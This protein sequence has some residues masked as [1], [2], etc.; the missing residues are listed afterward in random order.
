MA[1]V[2]GEMLVDS[3]DQNDTPV[4]V[5][6]RNE[7]FAKRVNFRVAHDLVFNSGGKLLV[8]QLARTRTRHP[9][10]WGSSVAAYLFSG[11][12]YEAAARR[13][14]A[15][16]LGIEGVPLSEVGKASMEDS[17]CQKFIGIFATIHDGPF[18]FD[19]EHIDAIEFL[20]LGEIGELHA[21]GSRRFTPTF[22][23]VLD[24]YESRM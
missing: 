8:Q 14:L 13:R 6:R 4:G 19:P 3:V 17:G 18:N 12:T 9:G 22:M 10:Y 2:S 5:V 7:V 15:Q 20:S 1:L 16:E 23:R 24:F 11:E 21:A